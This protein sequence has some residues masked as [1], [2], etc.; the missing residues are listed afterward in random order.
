MRHR[1]VKI[2]EGTL[3]TDVPE[4]MFPWGIAVGW[5]GAQGLVARPCAV[6]PESPATA[7]PCLRLLGGTKGKR[8][9]GRL[10]ST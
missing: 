7:R 9:F 3:G 2:R 1:L 4:L 10:G 5:V 8:V 6:S